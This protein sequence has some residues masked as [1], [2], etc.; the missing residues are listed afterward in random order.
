MTV[1][2]TCC[3]LLITHYPSLNFKMKHVYWV[4]EKELAGRPGPDME[5]WK[6]KALYKG[7]IRAIL[8]LN[9][10]RAVDEKALAKAG[11]EHYKISIPITEPPQMEAI[12]IATDL[13]PGAYAWVSQ[14]IREAKPVLVHC[15]HGNDRTGLFLLYFLVRYEDLTVQEALRKLKIIRPSILIAF[16][17]ENLAY[18][19]IPKLVKRS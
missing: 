4:R 12:E 5:P 8:T 15:S 10:G 14:K 13:L 3:S 11:L 1:F 7:G 17:W 18:E 16:G 6:P 9:G 19:L 2:F